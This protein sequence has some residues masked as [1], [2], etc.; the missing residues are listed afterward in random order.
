MSVL[1]MVSNVECRMSIVDCRDCQLM[2]ALLQYYFR[3]KI[4]PLL[5]DVVRTDDGHTV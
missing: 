2:S 4:L 1:L 5:S 3:F